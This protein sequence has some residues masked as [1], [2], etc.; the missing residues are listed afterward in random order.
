MSPSQSRRASTSR[1]VLPEVAPFRHSSR[2]ERDQYTTSSLANVFSN[3]SAFIHA[4]MSTSPVSASCVTAGIRPSSFQ[5]GMI[6]SGMCAELLAMAQY[7]RG[8]AKP[9]PVAGR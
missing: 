5:L 2:R 3:A 1:C 8:E 6:F 7:A 9:L 4:S